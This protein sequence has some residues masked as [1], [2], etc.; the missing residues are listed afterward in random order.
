MEKQKKNKINWV[1]VLGAVIKVLATILG[2]EL[3]G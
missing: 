1:N 3:I 2:V